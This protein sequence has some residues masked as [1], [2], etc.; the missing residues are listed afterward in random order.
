M[1][2]LSPCYRA[3]IRLKSHK[4]ILACPTTPY[5][6]TVGFPKA[7]YNGTENGGDG[8]EVAGQGQTDHLSC[9]R[10]T[11]PNPMPISAP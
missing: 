5:F 11:G 2:D 6:H 10:A 8:R 7:A 4:Q 9:A 1:Q 3:G